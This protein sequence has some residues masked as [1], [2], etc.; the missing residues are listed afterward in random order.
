ALEPRLGWGVFVERSEEAV[1]A[2]VRVR[3][4]LTV[5]VLLLAIALAA[6]AGRVVA[7]RLI[8]PLA[9][10]ARAADRFGEGDMTA[11]LPSS[12]IQEVAR[13]TTAFGALRT[14]LAART[15]ELETTAR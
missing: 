4:A 15:A 7:G 11:P 2:G 14:R 5:G 9:T 8:T 13:V 3:S 12:S 1:L 10:L 6:G